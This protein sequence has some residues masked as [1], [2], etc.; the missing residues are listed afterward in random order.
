MFRGYC[1]PIA[2][3][4]FHPAPPLPPNRTSIPE[5]YL[6]GRFDN[7]GFGVS[8]YRCP[9]CGGELVWDDERGEVTCSRCGLVV[10]RIYYYGPPRESEES[11]ERMREAARRHRP[12]SNRHEIARYRLHRERYYMARRYVEGKPWLEVDYDQV[13]E[14]G[15]MIHTIRSRATIEAEDN[16]EKLGLREPLEKTLKLIEEKYPMALA[17]TKRSRYALAYI[18]YTLTNKKRYPDDREVIEIFRISQTSYKRLQRIASR[19]IPIL[20][21]NPIPH[22]R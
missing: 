10:D 7:W 8:E 6:M 21:A 5:E 19:I 17:R 1:K 12:R 16:I 15:R 3:E 20:E 22:T 4:Y 2:Y 13:I 9:V 14:T 11:M 18:I